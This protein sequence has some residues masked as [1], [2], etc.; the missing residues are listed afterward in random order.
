MGHF[1]T[2]L[3]SSSDR[4]RIAAVDLALA[5]SPT[6]CEKL[7]VYDS[8]G[9]CFCFVFFL[10]TISQ[11]LSCIFLYY[12]NMKLRTVWCGSFQNLYFGHKQLM[13]V[14]F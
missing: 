2:L 9:V 5:T 8:G 4:P 7:L 12:I 1:A 10:V 13:T 11:V 3:R 6:L 14:S